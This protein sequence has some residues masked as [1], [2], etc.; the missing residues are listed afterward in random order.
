MRKL[1]CRQTAPLSS[2]TVRSPVE[3]ARQDINGRAH[4]LGRLSFLKDRK[5]SNTLSQD[6]MLPRKAEWLLPEHRAN[7]LLL[8]KEFVERA[9]EFIYINVIVARLGRDTYNAL[10]IAILGIP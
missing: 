10:V 5:K 8:G 2:G 6:D 4:K 9:S 3:P 7:C 1:Q